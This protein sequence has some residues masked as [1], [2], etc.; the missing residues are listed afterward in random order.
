M[1]DQFF[2]PF[3]QVIAAPMLAMIEGETIAARATTEFIES[4]GFVKDSTTDNNSF[5]K[6]RTV[7][8]SYVKQN[9]DGKNE[10]VTLTLPLL[11]LVPIPLLQIH[12]AEIEFGLDIAAKSKI[13]T[14]EVKSKSGTQILPSQKVNTYAMLKRMPTTSTAEHDIT[15]NMQM[16]VKIEIGQSDIPIGLSKLFQVFETSVQSKTAPPTKESTVGVIKASSIPPKKK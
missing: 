12:K 14:S 2:L 11:S 1:E 15:T 7:T 5:G 4:I 8:F 6:V 3:G 9:I 10:T 13:T 16:K